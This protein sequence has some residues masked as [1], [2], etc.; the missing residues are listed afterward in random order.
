VP[1]QSASDLPSAPW[2]SGRVLGVARRWLGRHLRL[3][4]WPLAVTGVLLSVSLGYSFWWNP[5]VHHTQGWVIPGDIWSTFRAAHWVG[6]GDLGGVYGSDT[7]LLTFPGIAVILAPVAMLSGSLGFTESIAPAYLGE[8]TS[9]FL[10]GPAIA[11]LGSTVLFAVDAVAEHLRVSRARRVV[12]C[13]MEAAI[14]F[15]V[16]TLWGHPEDVLAVSL[17][18]YAVLADLR[19]RTSLAAWLWGG[20]ICVQPLSLLM[21][22]LA[23]ARVRRGRRMR[24]GAV[25]ALP[26]AVLVGTPLAAQRSNSMNVLLHQANFPKLDHATPWIAYSPRLSS[27]TVG[28]GPGRLAALAVAVLLGLLAVRRPPT[29]TGVLWLCTLALCMRC[30]FESVMVPFYLGPPLALAVLTT[31]TANRWPRL[32]AS[33]VIAMAATVLSFRQTTTWAYW[34]PLVLLMAAALLCAW[35]TAEAVGWA[36]RRVTPTGGMIEAPDSGSHG[37]VGAHPIAMSSAGSQRIRA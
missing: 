11:L 13:W 28:A 10:L 4:I 27:I 9:W 17:A 1:N 34:I 37:A 18:L 32:L 14:A 23:I 3:R 26:S 8:P 20:A 15:Q 12:L 19:R 21:F 30:F 6:W 33:W 22:P 5:V 36:R 7:S 35:P 16:V 31:A 24:F 29:A 25:A 2:S